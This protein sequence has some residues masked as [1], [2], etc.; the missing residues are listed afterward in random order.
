MIIFIISIFSTKGIII[1]FNWPKDQ[2]YHLNTQK[3][4]SKS[5]Y[6]ISSSNSLISNPKFDHLFLWSLTTICTKIDYIFCNVC[7]AT[8]NLFYLQWSSTKLFSC[9]I[10]RMIICRYTCNI[11]ERCF[12]ITYNY[13]NLQS[14]QHICWHLWFQL[15]QNYHRNGQASRNNLP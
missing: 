5:I 13:S 14:F 3:L 4:N 1:D 2:L 10:N 9:R 12:Q 15:L 6:L 8:L 11:H 7:K